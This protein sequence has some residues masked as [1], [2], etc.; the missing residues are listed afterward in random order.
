MKKT[1]SANSAAL[2]TAAGRRG[3]QPSARAAQ[4]TESCTGMQRAK[5]STRVRA[6]MNK[7]SALPSEEKAVAYLEICAS[8]LCCKMEI[9]ENTA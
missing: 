1:V 9:S 4:C 3:R 7:R 8:E 6:K 5:A 2:M